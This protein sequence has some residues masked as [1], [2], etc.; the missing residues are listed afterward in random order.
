MPKRQKMNM[1]SS[2]KLFRKT[3]RPVVKVN[4]SKH[5]LKRGGMRL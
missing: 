5:Y 4:G 2:K 1:G 3:S